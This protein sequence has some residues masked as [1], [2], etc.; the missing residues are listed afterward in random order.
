[1][2]SFFNEH[3]LVGGG[4][5][6]ARARIAPGRRRIAVREDSQRR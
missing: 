1:M 5:Y 4:M 6:P 2:S 3:P